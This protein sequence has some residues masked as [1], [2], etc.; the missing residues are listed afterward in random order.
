MEPLP[1][2][3]VHQWMCWQYGHAWT[4]PKGW[5]QVIPMAKFSEIFILY[6]TIAHN[7]SNFSLFQ[8]IYSLVFNIDTNKPS[9]ATRSTQVPTWALSTNIC[10][11]SCIENSLCCFFI[12]FT[13]EDIF[14]INGKFLAA[15]AMLIAHKTIPH[16]LS[17]QELKQKWYGLACLQYLFYWLNSF[18]Q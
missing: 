4:M 3:G 18:L 2:G 7:A 15:L 10:I 14:T 13:F 8:T 1:S 9:I 16:F 5:F 12:F 17:L 6:K 11:I